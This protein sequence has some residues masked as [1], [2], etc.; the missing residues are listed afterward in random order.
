MT[1]G[2]LIAM[3]KDNKLTECGAKKAASHSLRLA[4]LP[5]GIPDEEILRRLLPLD[6]ERA[7]P[8]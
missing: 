5:P 8:G 3:R 2:K 4:G 7:V 1:P 6:Q